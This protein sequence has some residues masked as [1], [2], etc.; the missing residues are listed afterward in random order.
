[1][2]INPR[3]AADPIYLQ[4]LEQALSVQPL[5]DEI[6]ALY[7]RKSRSHDEDPDK[8]ESSDSDSDSEYVARMKKRWKQLYQPADRQSDKEQLFNFSHVGPDREWLKSVLLSDTSD[9]NSDSDS[10]DINHMLREHVQQKKIRRK[11]YQDPGKAK[12]CMYYSVGL[13]SN[14]DIYKERQRQRRSHGDSEKKREDGSSGKIKSE[15]GSSSDKKHRK[16][17][18]H[19]S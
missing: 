10:Y 8:T 6:E 16:S 5:V 18:K 1:M 2:N 9:S 3:P 4:R 15:P 11:Y 14:N 17:N 7:F 13:L 12:R 19:V